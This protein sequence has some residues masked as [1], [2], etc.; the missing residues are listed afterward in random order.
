MELGVCLKGGLERGFCWESL[1]VVSQFRT[2]RWQAL[3]PGTHKTGRGKDG[4]RKT[5]RLK[6]PNLL[7]FILFYFLFLII[8]IDSIGGKGRRLICQLML[9]VTQA[10]IYGLIYDSCIFLTF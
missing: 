1:S 8:N 2:H 5:V 6:Q 7:Y 3:I 4:G 10:K 9:S